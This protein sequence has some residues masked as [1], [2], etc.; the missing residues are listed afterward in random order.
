M[1][2]VGRSKALY[3]MMTGDTFDAA[4]ALRIGFIDRVVPRGDAIPTAHA[5]AQKI[6]ENPAT[7]VRFIKRS[8]NE[9]ADMPLRNAI[10]Y[11]AEM[12]ALLW[13]TEDHHEAETAFVE[14]RKPVFNKK[15]E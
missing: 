7:S 10:A 4:E 15:K 3:Y 12:L 9:G 8:I 11:E 2:L 5:I 13:G 6:A 14:K 1:R